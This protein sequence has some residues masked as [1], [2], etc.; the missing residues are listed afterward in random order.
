V[1]VWVRP[2][3]PS[4]KSKGLYSIIKVLDKRMVVVLDP[5]H[6]KSTAV[7]DTLGVK[8][9]QYSFDHVFEDYIDTEV[10][11]E[12]T[13]KFLLKQVCDGY[14]STVFAYGSTG[15]GKTHTMLGRIGS[16]GLFQYAFE[17]LFKE[18]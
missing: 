9:K 11:F 15:A 4:E 3:M 13:S 6:A 7:N 12:E 5:S 10:V 16:P 14:N 8:E 2:L 17:E 1:S 18:I